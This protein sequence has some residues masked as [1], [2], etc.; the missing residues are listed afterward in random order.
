MTDDGIDWA[1][2]DRR[3]R[4]VPALRLLVA[5]V[6]FLSGAVVLVWLASGYVDGVRYALN[7]APAIDLRAHLEE[8]RTLPPVGSLVT[9]TEVRI[10]A[11]GA[12]WARLRGAEMLPSDVTYLEVVGRVYPWAM[13]AD[14]TSKFFLEFAKGDL[15]LKDISIG[16]A[17]TVTGRLHKISRAA[18]F[19]MFIDYIA[20]T[21]ALDAEGAMLVADGELPEIGNQT[22][23]LWFGL[24]AAFVLNLYLFVRFLRAEV[25][26][27]RRTFS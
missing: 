22:L 20:K 6:M 9:L 16:Q 26:G 14:G 2:I 8:H 24:L 1:A 15:R 19:D 11:R 12:D 23:L 27:G 4:K 17:L 7:D 10:G 21:M 3:G 25:W 5:T 18:G 13:K